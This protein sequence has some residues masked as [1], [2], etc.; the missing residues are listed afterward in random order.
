MY[1]GTN[2]RER[3]QIQLSFLEILALLV[4]YFECTYCYSLTCRIVLQYSLM[5]PS[6]CFYDQSYTK[7]TA[8]KHQ[9]TF[10]PS[11]IYVR[12][13]LHGLTPEFLSP[14]LPR[15]WHVAMISMR[16]RNEINLAQFAVKFII[17]MSLK[18]EDIFL[19]FKPFAMVSTFS[20]L[21]AV[22]YIF[23]SVIN[24]RLIFLPFAFALNGATSLLP[25]L[26]SSFQFQLFLSR[27][28]VSSIFFSSPS[29]C[30]TMVFGF[31]ET[32]KVRES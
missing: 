9:L 1:I 13:F 25:S 8:G 2:T 4:L 24:F 15:L 18:R 7:N 26:R 22:I 32:G 12:L 19:I 27:K 28:W 30:Y 31:G 16:M 5:R 11:R 21:P 6:G 3:I 23:N 10:L 17:Q 20:L 29:Y 14:W